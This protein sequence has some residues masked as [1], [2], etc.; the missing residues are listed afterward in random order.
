MLV[1]LENNTILF[2]AQNT[3]CTFNQVE[4]DGSNH[5]HPERGGFEKLAESVDG[6]EHVESHKQ[7]VEEPKQFKHGSA[8]TVHRGGVHED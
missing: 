7:V 8:H 5:P 6:N 4:A 1:R 3:D 2:G